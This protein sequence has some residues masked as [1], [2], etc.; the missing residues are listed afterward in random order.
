MRIQTSV[1]AGMHHRYSEWQKV[2]PFGLVE[3]RDAPFIKVV[4][5]FLSLPKNKPGA[6]W[7]GCIFIA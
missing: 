5:W 4:T 6:D 1:L 2:N 3:F 7:H